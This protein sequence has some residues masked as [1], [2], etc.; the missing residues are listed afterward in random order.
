MGRVFIFK[1]QISIIYTH[2]CINTIFSGTKKKQLSER[3]LNISQ[4][5]PIGFAFSLCVCVC[6][7]VDSAFARRA[8]ELCSG[9]KHQQE[10]M[11]RCVKSVS[12]PLS[13]WSADESLQREIR[14]SRNSHDWAECELHRDTAGRDKDQ[15]SVMLKERALQTCGL[16]TGERAL[17]VQSLDTLL[18]SEFSYFHILE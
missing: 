14:P 6:L 17:L 8:Q 10:K 16:H 3:Y 18:F 1:N 4:N 9:G 13:S 5:F 15:M 2:E 7:V 12:L 11:S